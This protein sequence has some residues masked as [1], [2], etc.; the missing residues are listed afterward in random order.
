MRFLEGYNVVSNAV[1]NEVSTE[2]SNVVSNEV[3][4][5]VSNVSRRFAPVVSI[6]GPS[7]FSDR[8]VARTGGE[9]GVDGRGF[10]CILDYVW[11]SVGRAESSASPYRIRQADSAPTY[12]IRRVPVEITVG[13]ASGLLRLV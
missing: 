6:P 5:E 12:R 4:N 3:S 11:T 10:L 2:I 13:T 9:S 1:S 7:K 8:M